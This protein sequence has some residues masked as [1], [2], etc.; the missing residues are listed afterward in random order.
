MFTLQRD[1]KMPRNLGF[2]GID[3]GLHPLYAQSLFGTSLND[4]DGIL[5]TFTPHLGRLPLLYV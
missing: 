1:Y 2:T 5:S 3:R 4:P